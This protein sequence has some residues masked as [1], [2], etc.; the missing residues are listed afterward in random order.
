MEANAVDGPRKLS[1]EAN[2]SNELETD[3]IAGRGQGQQ[4][5]LGQAPRR[6]RPTTVIGFRPSNPPVEAK[7]G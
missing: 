1:V 4:W 6:L 5:A 3:E 7:D 2:D